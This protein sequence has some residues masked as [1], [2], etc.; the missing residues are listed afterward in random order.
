MLDILLL[1]L[2]LLLIASITR[3]ESVFTLFYLVA[4]ATIIGRW[5]SHRALKAVSFKRTFSRRAF[6][7]EIVPVRLEIANPGWLPVVWLHLQD[8]L[9]LELAGPNS[10]RQAISLGPH[11]RVQL[12]YQLQADKRGYYPVGPLF[13]RSGDLLGSVTDGPN[14]EGAP[15]HLTVYPKIV[16][17][18]RL[19]LPSWSPLGT[20]RHTQP[21]FEDPS[22]VLSKRSYVAGDSLRRIDWKASAAT[23]QLQVK[24]FEPSIALET[25]VCLNLNADEYGAHT[26]IDSTELAI[27]IAAS[28]ASWLVNQKQ[29]VGLITNGADPIQSE[30]HVTK[31]PP[32]KGRGNLMR[33]LDVLARIQM[34]ETGPLAQLL[35]QQIVHLAWGATLIVITGQLDEPLLRA[36]FQARRA[37][38]NALIILVGF[39]AELGEMERRAKYFGFAVYHIRTER[40]LDMWRH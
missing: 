15:D 23:S 3:E 7:A 5:W 18:T 27:V 9:P 2:L 40:D 37:G 30:G 8:N 24:Q 19:S 39:G 31:L 36:L 21:I 35:H 20:L 10:F 25:A 29:S 14:W 13:L 32:R 34:T 16:P 11:A 12:D 17:L 38:L 4:G 6:L 28:I 33:I 22:R 1:L 26:R